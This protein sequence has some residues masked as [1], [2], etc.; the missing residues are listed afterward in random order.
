VYNINENCAKVIKLIK[1]ALFRNGELVNLVKHGNLG[2]LYNG[3]DL[4]VNELGI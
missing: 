2:D 3:N 1:F 4:N